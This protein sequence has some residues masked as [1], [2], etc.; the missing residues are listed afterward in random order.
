MVTAAANTSPLL[1]KAEMSV[2]ILL[3]LAAVYLH[4]IAATFAGA[5][6]RDEVAVL[7]LA[8]LPT[9]GEVWANLDHEAFPMLWPIDH[10]GCSY[11]RNNHRDG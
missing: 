1:R 9:L 8:T 11:R 7:G 2:G 4:V 10:Q 5:L 3:T 6:W